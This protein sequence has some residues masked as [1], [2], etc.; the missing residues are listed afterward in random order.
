MQSSCINM[1]LIV[2]L[3]QY[4][5]ST[6]VHPPHHINTNWPT[7]KHTN[8]TL[9]QQHFQIPNIH[10]HIE[11]C[12]PQHVICPFNY[13][14]DYQKSYNFIYIP[15]VFLH[16]TSRVDCGCNESPGRW[17]RLYL[18]PVQNHGL[19]LSCAKQNGHGQRT[20][21]VRSYLELCTGNDP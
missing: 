15:C 3:Y 11:E 12:L 10:A 8:T 9:T 20:I 7:S 18:L 16:Q 17:H 5:N 6:A 19:V 21:R 13:S 4:I 2:I 1:N 14:K